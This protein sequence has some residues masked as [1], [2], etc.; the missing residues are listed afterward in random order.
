[1]SWHIQK[2]N[3]LDR[4]NERLRF[5]HYMRRFFTLYTKD[6]AKQLFYAHIET[7]VHRHVKD[8]I[9]AFRFHIG[10]R[11]SETP[12]DGHLII[13][14]VGFYWALGNGRKLADKLTCS[15]KR[16]FDS[17]DWSLRIHDSSVWWEFANHNDMYDRGLKNR[18]RGYFNI[19][20]P[21]AF[22]GPKKYTY[23]D[24]DSYATTIKMPEGEYA[25]VLNLQKVY[26]G[27]TKVAKRKHI[28][29][30]CI[31]VDS[32]KGIPTH[33][34]KSGGWKGD[35]TYGFGVDFK[36]P[37]SQNWQQDAEAVVTSYVYKCR[38][39]SGFREPQEV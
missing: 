3:E 38:G 10:N 6:E 29:T 23:E 32:P 16:P 12:W 26:F 17:R 28:Q 18:R 39:D 13:L 27:R 20:I 31:D 36:Y 25:V 1:M 37:S 24:I 11:G 7:V 35:R 21:E 22:W 34:D 5:F 19:S 4:G 9:F 8:N 2:I 15:A 33:Y 30:W 14:G